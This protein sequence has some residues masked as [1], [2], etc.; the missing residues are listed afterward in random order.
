MYIRISVCIHLQVLRL[1]T[2]WISLQTLEET[3]LPQTSLDSAGIQADLDCIEV[4]INN[5]H[6]VLTKE[7]KWSVPLLYCQELELH[8]H[9][10]YD[11]SSLWYNHLSHYDALYWRRGR[12]KLKPKNWGKVCMY[13]QLRIY[14]H[15]I[16]IIHFLKV[17]GRQK[18]T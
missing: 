10:H 6:T 17:W 1:S 7:R 2:L 9:P 3:E 5:I 8:R 14:I 18:L 16:I 15:T 11:M 4:Y 13:I 12:L